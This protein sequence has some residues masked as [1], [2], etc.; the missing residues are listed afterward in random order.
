MAKKLV[1]MIW[2][3]YICYNICQRNCSFS[4][5]Q[6]MHLES[7]LVDFRLLNCVLR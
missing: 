7:L 2:C 5:R 6:N 4:L 3:R 1:K